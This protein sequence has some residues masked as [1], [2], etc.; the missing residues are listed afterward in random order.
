MLL[1][2]ITMTGSA[3]V[4]KHAT[5]AAQ[6]FKAKYV[7]KTFFDPSV[8]SLIKIQSQKTFTNEEVYTAVHK[9]LT[10]KLESLQ[11]DITYQL[12]Y[13]NRMKVAQAKAPTVDGPVPSDNWGDPDAELVE[14][15]KKEEALINQINPIREKLRGSRAH[16]NLPSVY[17]FLLNAYAVN[18]YGRRIIVQYVFAYKIKGGLVLDSI[19]KIN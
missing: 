6:Q 14:M 1:L 9:E 3:Q 11:N 18:Q 13:I 12:G 19:T 8:Y 17:V 5:I 10:G 7:N 16:L 2:F 4:N 15:R